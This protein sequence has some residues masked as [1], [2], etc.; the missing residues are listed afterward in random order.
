MDSPGNQERSLSSMTNFQLGIMKGIKRFAKIAGIIV[1]PKINRPGGI[2]NII[3]FA[4]LFGLF[5]QSNKECFDDL[6]VN[7]LEWSLAFIRHG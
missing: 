6:R 3:L 5:N 2:Q 7:N 1:K 4:N